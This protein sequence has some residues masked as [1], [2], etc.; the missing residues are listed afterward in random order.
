MS[1]R[2]V[3]DLNF[4]PPRMGQAFWGAEV[5]KL[6]KVYR[7]PIDQADAKAITEYLAKTMKALLPP[8]WCRWW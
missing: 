8:R 6:I 3:D 4:Q 7:V 2:P 1:C 5:Q